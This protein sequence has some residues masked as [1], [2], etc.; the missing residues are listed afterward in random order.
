[1]RTSRA[2]SPRKLPVSISAQRREGK[3]VEEEEET[4][5]QGSATSRV[6]E[7][8][9]EAGGGGKEEDVRDEEEEEEEFRELF[10][11]C[12]ALLSRLGL[13]ESTSTTA[14][15]LEKTEEEVAIG[16]KGLR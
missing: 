4:L 7:E 10:S 11:V 8:E 6:S 9:E 15:A 5:K 13:F 16:R 14:M 3:E 1:M 12:E 2:P